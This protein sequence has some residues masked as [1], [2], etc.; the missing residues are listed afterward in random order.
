MGGKEYPPACRQAGKCKQNKEWQYLK[1]NFHQ[2]IYSLADCSVKPSRPSPSGGF[3]QSW[4]HSAI[5]F[6]KSRVG[7]RKKVFSLRDYFSVKEERSERRMPASENSL[8]APALNKIFVWLRSVFLTATLK[9]C[10]FIML[11]LK[12]KNNP[13]WYLKVNFHQP[14]I[15]QGHAAQR[16]Q[17]RKP[18]GC[19]V[20]RSS[21][22][23]KRSGVLN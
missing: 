11:W 21:F 13:W 15:F 9:K 14:S 12:I 4:W 10:F 2:P 3:R 19:E 16:C 23:S 7:W 20:K 5:C 6:L 1:V 17:S 22:D 8:T 18:K